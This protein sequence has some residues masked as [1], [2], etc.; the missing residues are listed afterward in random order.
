MQVRY[1][2]FWSCVH[3]RHR[4]KQVAESCVITEVLRLSLCLD[5]DEC[6]IGT[7]RCGVGQICHNLPGSYRCDCQTGYQYDALRKVCT[8]KQRLHLCSYIC[9]RFGQE[10][11]SKWFVSRN[12]YS[13][14]KISHWLLWNPLY[15][16]KKGFLNIHTDF[17]LSRY[18]FLKNPFL[19]LTNNKI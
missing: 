4:I 10:V 16:T 8:G 18:S 11:W 14:R 7:H 5:I 1:C 17:F 15:S 3:E 9:E 19:L 6:Q 2:D 13:C 12:C